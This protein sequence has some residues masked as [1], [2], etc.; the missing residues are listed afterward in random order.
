MAI[1]MRLYER[2][3]A[4]HSRLAPAARHRRLLNA[5]PPPPPGHIGEPGST[6]AMHADMSRAESSLRLH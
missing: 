2:Q 4:D 3:N 5:D 1:D 6:L